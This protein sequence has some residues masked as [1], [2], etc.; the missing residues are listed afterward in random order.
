[1]SLEKKLFELLNTEDKS[2]DQEIVS[3]LQ[4][5][6][7]SPPTSISISTSPPTSTST[8]TSNASTF[9]VNW[10]NEKHGKW[11]LLQI[12]CYFNHHEIVAELLKLPG[13]NPNQRGGG[14]TPFHA[15][16]VNNA[17]ESVCLML[18]DPRVDGHMGLTY[19]VLNHCVK[20]IEC[21]LASLR[22][23]GSAD[24]GNAII[25]A[26][27]ETDPGRYAEMV[28]F[29]EEYQ[30]RPFEVTKQLRAKLNLQDY[31]PVSVFVLVVLL[32]DDYFT[33]K[34]FSQH[35][36]DPPSKQFLEFFA[37]LFR[38]LNRRRASSPPKP[39]VHEEYDQQKAK[40]ACRFFKILLKLPIDLQMTICNRLFDQPKNIIRTNS[41]N[42][43]LRFMVSDG[44][45]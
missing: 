1:M 34:V 35:E 6:P 17:V 4:S 8:S 3:L 16:C 5:L 24:I 41:V 19:A 38:S 15:A 7:S 43:A 27:K 14:L 23:V 36:Q 12:A 25:E 30:A 33:L 18:N 9:N 32:C 26:K 11:G 20:V 42:M 29:L 22:H 37:N 10:T 21:I 28:S 13:I 40:G 39:I 45:L 2:K 44:F 31:G